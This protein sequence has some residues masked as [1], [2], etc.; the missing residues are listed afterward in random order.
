MNL[1]ELKK[2]FF[3]SL[4]MTGEQKTGD[5]AVS[6]QNC[7]ALPDRTAKSYPYVFPTNL[8]GLAWSLSFQSLLAA[9]VDFD[10]LGLGFRLLG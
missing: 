10:L 2:R 6:R 8:R 1:F 7:R 3:A 5:V 9:N 4:R